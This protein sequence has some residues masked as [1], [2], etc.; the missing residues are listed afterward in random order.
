LDPDA[1]VTE[2][3]NELLGAVAALKAYVAHLPARLLWTSTRSDELHATRVR[4]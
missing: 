4:A 1:D 2:K 3:I